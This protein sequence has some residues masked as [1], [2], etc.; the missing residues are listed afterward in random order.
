M[1]ELKTFVLVAFAAIGI[2]LEVP[3]VSMHAEIRVQYLIPL[4]LNCFQEHPDLKG[5]LTAC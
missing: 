3:H 4:D 1:R 2:A 5:E